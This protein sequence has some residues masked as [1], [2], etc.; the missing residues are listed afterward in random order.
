MLSVCLRSRLV[1]NMVFSE[2]GK[3]RAPKS[4]E[5]ALRKSA[6]EKKFSREP[7]LSTTWSSQNSPWAWSPH[8]GGPQMLLM[9]LGTQLSG[10]TFW[11]QTILK[12]IKGEDIDIYFIC[13]GGHKYNTFFKDF[14]M[15]VPRWWMFLYF[16]MLCKV[17]L[18]VFLW[19]SLVCVFKCVL[20]WPAWE[21]A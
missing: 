14:F 7:D 12:L 21:E 15:C 6:Q 19:F 5:K 3:P 11:L 8:I 4:E 9:Y 1:Y 20:K 17:T 10:P 13:L 18:V 2:R 16:S